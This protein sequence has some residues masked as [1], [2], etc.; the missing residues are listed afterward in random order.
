MN[1]KT[2][3]DFEY[4]SKAH[5]THYS[6]MINRLVLNTSVSILIMLH[7]DKDQS[8]HRAIDMTIEGEEYRK[9]GADDSYIHELIVAR[10]AKFC[11]PPAAPPAET[12]AE[13]PAPSTE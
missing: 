3:V 7:S 8:F 4:V 11:A 9:W 1:D 6:Y 5:V 10:I 2:A 13:P 12:P